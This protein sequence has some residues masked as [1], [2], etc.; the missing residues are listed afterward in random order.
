MH[1]WHL[2]ASLALEESQERLTCLLLLPSEEDWWAAP[3]ANHSVP[4][5]AW[6]LFLSTREIKSRSW[7]ANSRT[8]KA[9]YSL[10]TARS[11]AYM[12]KKP[13]AKKWTV[14]SGSLDSAGQQ[15]QLPIHPSNVQIVTLKL[16]KD[17]KALLE[18]KKRDD[19]SKNKG[20]GL[21]WSDL[22]CNL[23]YYLFIIL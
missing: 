9:K 20:M 12:L 19:K 21:D 18:R 10:S 22:I 4:S 23:S 3:W 1:S 7:E 15:V 13:L 6:D 5:T 17:R 16:D 11:G 14:N 8:E 2:K